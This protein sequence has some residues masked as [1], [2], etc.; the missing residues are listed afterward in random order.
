MKMVTQ[1]V[2]FESVQDAASHRKMMD[3]VM[4]RVVANITG[5]QT[6][7]DRRCGVSKKERKHEIENNCQRNADHRR[8]NQAFRVVR[9]IVVNAVHDEMQL[10]PNR[11]LRL[12]MKNPAMDYV[13]EQGPDH[14]TSKEE[15]A[16]VQDRQFI[17]PDRDVKRERDCG[18]VDH[19]WRGRMDV[20]EKLHEIAFEYP[21]RFVLFG[22]V[23]LV[24]G[25]RLTSG[26][27]QP[28]SVLLRQFEKRRSLP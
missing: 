9:I 14:H 20:G 6:G 27:P 3:R 24:H 5:D 17:S 16:N 21:N 4:N 23:E 26:P 28:A 11:A 13:L 15:R 25:E 12:V 2:L 19:E 7:P 8:H 1:M 18:K 22:N 10:F